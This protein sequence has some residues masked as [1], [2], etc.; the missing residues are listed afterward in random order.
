[1][2][3]FDKN[4]FQSTKQT[5]ETPDSLFD[6]LNKEFHFTLD[7]AADSTNA[8]CKKFISEMQDALKQSW[9]GVCW[10]NPP[11]NQLGKWVRKA[12][13]EA[14]EGRATTVLLI[15]SRTNTEWWHD[16]CNLGEIRFVRG[17]PKFVGCKHGLPQPLALVIFEIQSLMGGSGSQL[18]GQQ[19]S[20][21]MQRAPA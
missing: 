7:V 1:M 19:Q 5:Y 10:C 8:K 13:T 9:S 21:M 2:G 3:N 18:N 16:Y 14:Q 17:R 4:R 6:P 15:P 12:F 11:Y 20:A